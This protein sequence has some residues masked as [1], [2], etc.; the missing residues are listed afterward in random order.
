MT[1]NVCLSVYCSRLMLLFFYVHVYVQLQVETR[2]Q[3][4][5]T[6]AFLNL[7]ILL[8]VYVCVP[9]A[10]VSLQ[11]SEKSTRFSRTAVM[12][13]CELPYGFWD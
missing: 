6:L 5:S 13:N 12:G 3:L 8:Y 1:G 11:M 7:F 4:L 2:P 9:H 10:C